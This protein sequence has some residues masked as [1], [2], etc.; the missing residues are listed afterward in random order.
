LFHRIGCFAVKE[1]SRP[2]P[3]NNT[4]IL[5]GTSGTAPHANDFV[6]RFAY[7]GWANRKVLDACS[8]VPD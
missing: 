7:D 2:M 6:A 5:Y 4:A 1:V 8:S 3:P